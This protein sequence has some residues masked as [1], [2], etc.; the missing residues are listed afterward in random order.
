MATFLAYTS[1]AAGHLFPVVPGLLALQARGHEVHLRTAPGHVDAVRA[2][3]L[4][5]AAPVAAEVAAYETQVPPV[6]RDVDELRLGLAALIGRGPLERA[7][8]E[9]AIA[10]VRPDALLIDTNV[11][12]AAVAAEASGLPWATTLPSLLPLPGKGIPPYGLGLKPARRPLGRVR[13]AVLWRL[14]ERTFG[15]AMLP[16]LNRLRAQAGLAPYASPLEHLR[17]PDRLIVLTGE[18]LEYPRAELEPHVRMVGAQSWDPPAQA[19]A[20]L[21]EP[22]DPWVL[23]T[24]STEYQ[25]DESLALTAVEALRDEPV[26]VLLTIADAEGA[27]EIPAAG[28]VRVERFVAHGPVLERAAAVVC[29]S[30]MGIVQKAVAHGVPIVAV[31]FG[32]DQP[33]VS[34]RVA[35]GGAGV[36]LRAKDL[37]PERLRACVREAM[38]MTPGRRGSGG[39]ELFADAA[40]ELLQPHDRAARRQVVERRPEEVVA[41]ADGAPADP[42]RAHAVGN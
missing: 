20:W 34:R 28:N 26:R 23:V 3:G 15:K 8:L 24:L 30:G 19:P 35:E 5:H 12:G 11:Y 16:P 2:A 39:P 9:R 38:A 6:K 13:D 33:E 42:D 14:A 36:R 4:A 1:P 32:R 31:P 7:D 21:D 18:P 40:E 10:E 25:Q 41:D 37:S 17:K 27:A 29:H 22:G